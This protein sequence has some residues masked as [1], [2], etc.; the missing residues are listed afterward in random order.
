MVVNVGGASLST[1]RW[2]GLP[3]DAPSR[4]GAAG[5]G[6]STPRELTRF[7][8][9]LSQGEILKP[10]TFA[11]MTRSRETSEDYGLGIV[12]RDRDGSPEYWHNGALEPHGYNA[13]ISTFP[14]WDTTVTVLVARGTMVT[15]A[16]GIAQRLIDAILG[17]EYRSPFADGVMDWLMANMSAVAFILIPAW[18]LIRLVLASFREIRTPRV[19]WA[20]G[21]MN[22][23]CVLIF[24]RGLLGVH[25]DGVDLWVWPAGVGGVVTAMIWWRLRNEHEQPLIAVRA[26]TWRR[27]LGWMSLLFGVL[28]MPV[29]GWLAGAYGLHFAIMVALAIGCAVRRGTPAT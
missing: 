2:L 24:L 20:V 11:E 29:V 25:G 6:F 1:T 18:M 23:A 26:S 13:H 14:T 21:V 28:I 15:S 22:N 10:E 19:S 5:N 12:N 7:F 4:V 27:V 8:E 17:K 3:E 16:T 9:A